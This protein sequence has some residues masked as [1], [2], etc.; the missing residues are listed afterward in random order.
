MNLL[1]RTKKST[2]ATCPP[3]LCTIMKVLCSFTDCIFYVLHRQI[4]GRVMLNVGQR[5]QHSSKADITSTIF[6]CQFSDLP[7]SAIGVWCE[8]F[9]S[10]SSEAKTSVMEM[11]WT[12]LSTEEQT[13]VINDL[14][15]FISISMNTE[16]ESDE[17]QRNDI[18]P[19]M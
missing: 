4:A 7:R 17:E 1:C 8:F 3:C 9:L 11:M 10:L 6:F 14:R 12:S 16:Y 13:A 15:Q 5:L 2:K 19:T 18:T